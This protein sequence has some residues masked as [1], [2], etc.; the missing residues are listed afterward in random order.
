MSINR[1]DL[2]RVAFRGH[3]TPSVGLLSPANKFWFDQ[4]LKPQTYDPKS[5]LELLKQDGFHK[6]G[7]V[8]K[9]KAGN[10]VVFSLITNSG[11][12]PRERMGSLMQQDLAQIGISLNF[13]P[14]DFP[15]IIERIT[16]TFDYEACMLGLTNVD[17]DPDGQM[18]VWLSSSDLHQWNPAQKAPETSWEMD[19]D[20]LMHAQASTL[21]RNKRKA[22][23][24]KVQEIVAAQD[25]MLYLVDKN[26]L[27]AVS[28]RVKGADPVVLTPETFWNVEYLSLN[29][30]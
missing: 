24:N 16:K 28:S 3:A 20:K 14:L 18:N 19:I 26:A 25:P 5:A 17:L 22:E 9:D 1:P 15:S 23:F 6:D 12:R 8:L 4:S 29:R 27:V 21:D 13:V 11:N 2:A 7:D 30:N 10:P